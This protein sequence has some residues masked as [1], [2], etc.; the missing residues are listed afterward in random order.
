MC[1]ITISGTMRAITI[2][3]NTPPQLPLQ[4]GSMR[5]FAPDGVEHI[6][7]DGLHMVRHRYKVLV[8]KNQ[9]ACRCIASLF[10]ADC[11]EVGALIV[12]SPS[13]NDVTFRNDLDVFGHCGSPDGLKRGGVDSTNSGKAS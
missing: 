9:D 3:G 8:P 6:V 10:H 5:I 11:D 12:D 2:T 4:P 7:G 13:R 1:N